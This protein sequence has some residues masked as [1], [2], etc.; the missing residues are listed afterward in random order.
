LRVM[1]HSAVSLCKEN[2]IDVIV[3]SLLESGTMARVACG[4]KLGTLITRD[5]K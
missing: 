5:S 1:D 3:C 2:N 4:E